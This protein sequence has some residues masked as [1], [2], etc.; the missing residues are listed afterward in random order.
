MKHGLTS[1]VPSAS[2]RTQ[3]LRVGL[4]D[5]TLAEGPVICL[6]KRKT[7]RSTEAMAP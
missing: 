6:L 3:E 7:Q 4:M 2:S 5:L 1:K